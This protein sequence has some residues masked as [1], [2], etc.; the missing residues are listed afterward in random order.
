MDQIAP[1]LQAVAAL[2]WVCFAFVALLLFKSELT[3]A[4]G[5]LSE[6]ELFG[7]KFKLGNDLERLEISVAATEREAQE[8]P[9]GQHQSPVTEEG[10]EVDVLVATIL[11]QAAKSPKVALILLAAELEKAA[12]HALA[13]RGLLGGRSFVPTIQALSELQQYGFPPNMSG[14]LRL[15]NEIRNKIVHG[16]SATDDDALRALDSGITILRAVAA[17]PNETKVVHSV[18]VDLFSDANCK[19]PIVGAK[20]VVLETTSPGGVTKTLQ[21]FPST[22]THFQKGKEV[23][24]EWDLDRIWPATWYRDLDTAETKKAWDSSGE[25]VGRH[26]DDI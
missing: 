21:I 9:S 18:G 25:F 7:Q 16:V 19:D 23:A 2:G 22:R 4:L 10:E 11:R 8:T 3:Q 17:L 5:R 24:W 26:L 6:G 1:V 12:R 14:S 20:G 13:R 15:F